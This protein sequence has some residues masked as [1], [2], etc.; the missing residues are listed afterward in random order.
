MV[1]WT[2]ARDL[3]ASAPRYWIATTN[4]N[5]SPHV[6]QQWGA[7]VDDRFFFEGSP[8]TRWGRNITR[9]PATVVST[10]AADHALILHGVGEQIVPETALAERIADGYATKYLTSD[11]YRPS[12]EGWS[13]GCLFVVR[14]R[15]L[16]AWDRRDFPRTATRFT[17]SEPGRRNG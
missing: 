15:Y 7:W 8:Q 16:L 12:P 14:P 1:A 11:G 10:E 3:F 13:G 4:A 5:G 2:R 6:V 9:N 17:F